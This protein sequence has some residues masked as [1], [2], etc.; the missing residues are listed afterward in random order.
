M[1]VLEPHP[2][3]TKNYAEASIESKENVLMMRC[4]LECMHIIQFILDYDLDLN[5]RYICK[6]FQKF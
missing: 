2:V 6:H 5:V 3:V 1:R 4:K